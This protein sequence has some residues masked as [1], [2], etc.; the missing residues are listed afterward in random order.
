MIGRSKLSSYLALS[1]LVFFVPLRLRGE[2]LHWQDRNP[3]KHKN[4]VKYAKEKALY[5]KI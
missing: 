4:Y 3:R 2:C 1:F 5:Q